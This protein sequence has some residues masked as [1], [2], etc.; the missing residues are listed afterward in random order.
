[1]A[2]QKTQTY[3]ALVQFQAEGGARLKAEL[4]EISRIAQSIGKFD[5]SLQAK[6]IES[7]IKD[8][9]TK[10]A[11][12]ALP[13]N[14]LNK[15]AKDIANSIQRLPTFDIYNEATFKENQK[16]IEEIKAQIQDAEKLQSD[17]TKNQN[18]W[19]FG[20]Q[21]FK[22]KGQY[23]YSGV[24]LN[25]QRNDLKKEDS[26]LKGYSFTSTKEIQRMMKEVDI[27]KLNTAEKTLYNR[28]VKVLEV[29]EKQKEEIKQKAVTNQGTIDVSKEELKKAEELSAEYEKHKQELEDINNLK[30]N[31]QKDSS[32]MMSGVKP[33]T[34]N[35]GLSQTASENVDKGTNEE[36]SDQENLRQQLNMTD[37]AAS[38][39]VNRFFS[40]RFALSMISKIASNVMSTMKQLD[41]AFNE[42]AVVSTY[43]TKEV[44]GMYDSFLSIANAT[45]TASKEI[46]SV[47]GEYFK[48]GKS[49]SESLVL[50]EAAATA[51]K[52][53]GI[54]ARES[55]R[56]LTAALNGYKLEATEAMAVSD[57]FS[58]LAAVSATDYADLAIALGKVAAQANA[59]GVKM[60]SLLGFMT[61]AL[62][63]TQEAPENIG[64]AFKTIFARMSEIKD[65]GKT[66]EDN[67]SANKVSKALASIGIA[68]F[69]TN[70]EMRALDDVLMEVG[71][72]W[73]TL[74]SVQ[75][76]YI[77]TALAGTRQQTR[78]ISIFQDWGK[79][80]RYVQDSA[81]SSGSTIAQMSKYTETIQYSLEKLN[82]AWEELI[83]S[84]SNSTFIKTL[85]DIVTAVVKLFSAWNGALAKI[86]LG[87]GGLVGAIAIVNNLQKVFGLLAMSL[88]KIAGIVKGSGSI[89]VG[90]KLID[91]ILTSLSKKVPAL[92]G[93]ISALQEMTSELGDKAAASGAGIDKL[94]K[95]FKGLGMASKIGIGLGV[96][97]LIG[98]IF[99][100]GK[101]ATQTSRAKKE[102]QKLYAEIYNQKEKI[103]NVKDLVDEYK[104][105][106]KTLI[107]TTDDL[108][109][110]NSI[111]Q[112]IDEFSETNLF[113]LSG[114]ID[115][116]A[117]KKWLEEKTEEQIK[118]S[119][120]AWKNIQKLPGWGRKD[121]TLGDA[122]Y[123]DNAD[124]ATRA[125]AMQ[126]A[127]IQALTNNYEDLDAAIEQYYRNAEGYSLEE[128]REAEKRAKLM[129]GL[130]QQ[131]NKQII[132]KAGKTV[133]AEDREKYAHITGGADS[134]E[135][136]NR[137]TNPKDEYNDQYVLKRD[138]V[139][140]DFNQQSLADS[141]KEKYNISAADLSNWILGEETSKEATENIEQLL[142]TSVDDIS[143]N[144]GEGTQSF[145]NV[146]RQQ[147]DQLNA[148]ITLATLNTGTSVQEFLNTMREAGLTEEGAKYLADF[149]QYTSEDSLSSADGMEAYVAKVQEAYAAMTTAS[150]DWVEQYK[151]ALSE[152]NIESQYFNTVFLKMRDDL[153]DADYER[154]HQ[155]GAAIVEDINKIN[156]ALSDGKSPE[157]IQEI[158]NL[159]TEYPQY[160]EEIYDSIEKE[161]KISEE[162][163]K[164][165]L[166]TKQNE[167]VHR[168]TLS[169]EEDLAEYESFK[170]KAKQYAKAA[171]TGEKIDEARYNNEIS[172][173]NDRI[174]SHKDMLEKLLIQDKEYSQKEEALLNGINVDLGVSSA[175]VKKINTAAINDVSYE[176]LAKMASQQ[177]E[178]YYASYLAKT[179]ILNKIKNDELNLFEGLNDI[180]KDKSSKSSSSAVKE[181][182]AALDELYTITQ[183]IAG[184][185]AFKKL[186]DA[187]EK[188]FQTIKDG[189]SQR[190]IDDNNLKLLEREIDLY[191]QKSK[192]IVKQ[193]NLLASGLTKEAASIIKVDNETGRLILDFERYDKTT[194]KV[195]KEIDDFSKAWEELQTNWEDAQTTYWNLM[196]SIETLNKK[197]ID[198]TITYQNQLKE[199]FIKYY[200]DLYKQQ[201]NALN[202]EKELLNERKKLYQEAFTD[203]EHQTQL[204]ELDANRA[205]ILD[206]LA[207]LEGAMDTKSKQERQKLLDELEKANKEYNDK[208]TSYNKDSLNKQIDAQ[209]KAIDEQSKN[210]TELMNDVPKQVEMLEESVN[211]LTSKGLEA[212][213]D[214]LSEWSD[215]WQKAL[216]TERDKIKN[217]WTE[218][219]EYLYGD[220]AVSAYQKYYDDLLQKAKDTYA[221]IQKAATTGAGSSGGSGGSGSSGSGSKNDSG[222]AKSAISDWYFGNTSLGKTTSA[223]AYTKLQSLLMK[224]GIK[225]SNM[226]N[227]HDLPISKSP[228]N[229]YIVTSK[230]GKILW[231]RPEEW[232]KINSGN[233]GFDGFGQFKKGGYVKYTGPAWVDGTPGSPEAFL[234]ARQTEMF[235]NLT[236]SLE[237][238]YNNSSNVGHN[239]GTINIESITIK[240]D[241]LNT[242]QD[243]EKAGNT[244]ANSL[245]NALRQ[246]GIVTNL[247]R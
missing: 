222:G 74:D 220:T 199:A 120:E 38:R 214:F 60:D 122:Y 161:G 96:A 211:E 28:A 106:D 93:E 155:E 26:V 92:A 25:Q 157:A 48:Q 156:D 201:I 197:V 95:G 70:N 31:A 234:N 62:E 125:Q 138:L 148:A 181:Y 108:E 58:K 72:K 172:N 235:E 107:K 100:I 61:T 245:Q 84:I 209:S 40:L 243:F 2:S 167:Y 230:N 159:M 63:V 195:K 171:E 77:T 56:Y 103:N 140:E 124:A 130:E 23:A 144:L 232:K 126:L 118:S 30:D 11:Q 98:F 190:A 238:M 49:L 216:S 1:M 237:K 131:F 8:L 170:E 78:L 105:L 35:V 147:S 69:D 37:E 231:F 169:A 223:A 154:V 145:L 81:D 47:A 191:D 51:A 162:T 19:N 187:A 46:I 91:T 36:I 179:M 233:P 59:S 94:I 210:L 119:K 66:L 198:K 13:A 194:D 12:E 104:K 39:L 17:L 50:T 79:T 203:Q 239:E 121:G 151:Q 80:M 6:D 10:I 22:T 9:R 153:I 146:L 241:E 240:T 97:A 166:A 116:E 165:I 188:Y 158:I 42:I 139:I 20:K 236:H 15:M 54:D 129:L 109:K 175:T 217:D 44:W 136:Y 177:A 110:M 193:Q 53:A 149:A 207:A 45:G 176:A 206:K 182:T 150:D 117:Y 137:I 55:V 141:I 163:S 134:S 227:L 180:D 18:L 86:V 152:A 183:K 52:V 75:Q 87:I 184:L 200:Q 185:D 32:T 99:Y 189:A 135:Y 202:K 128:T 196:N 113:T 246:R 85:I 114:S 111:R 90:F 41:S 132:L 67:T 76:K 89:T 4:G 224:S 27:E 204:S 247:K 57:K 160:M 208:V 5:L 43:T 82:N 218:L 73:D 102:I 173:M 33:Y 228:N 143:K 127:T 16:R 244:L 3:K 226:S 65:Y 215:Q 112:Q 68:L 88:V 178:S 64:T 21:K 115:D 212:V 34:T 83:R 186:N 229:Q 164:K 168:L 221:N 225:A 142:N 205:T 71:E 174:E 219:Y 213:N 24:D 242:N 133:S 29:Y 123:G 101:L 7:Q 192:I 14:E